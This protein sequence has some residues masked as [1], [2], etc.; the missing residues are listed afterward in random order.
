MDSRLP[1]ELLLG[2]A[3]LV[4]VVATGELF[5]GLIALLLFRILSTLLDI[6]DRIDETNTPTTR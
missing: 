6:R 5:L 3:I 2:V 1:L 4:L